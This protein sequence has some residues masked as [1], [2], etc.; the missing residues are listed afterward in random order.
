MDG[1]QYNLFRFATAVLIIIGVQASGQVAVPSS[2]AKTS[3]FVRVKLAKLSF[4]L[5]IEGSGVSIKGA[6][7][8]AIEQASIPQAKKIRVDF[9]KIGGRPLWI[10]T[11]G[12]KI[13]RLNNLFLEI[14][15]E[16]TKVR[17]SGFEVPAPALLSVKGQNNS[18]DVVSAIKFDEYLEG[19]M[20]GEMPAGWP[21]EALKAQAVAARSYTL[22]QMHA[23]QREIYQLEGSILDQAF[24]ISTTD[25]Q[26]EKIRRAIAATENMV[27]FKGNEIL[28]A[29]YHS[30]CG[31][32]TE[33]PEHIWGEGDRKKFAQ[34][35]KDPN[36][37]FNPNS[38]WNLEVTFEE[39]KAFSDFK[40]LKNIKD[41]KVVSRTPS[42][43]ADLIA[44]NDGDNEVVVT[45]ND[46]RKILGYGKLKSTLFSMVKKEKSLVFI[47]RGFGHGSGLCQF[48]AK[49][50]AE[51]G[52]SVRE[53][54]KH[55]YP[56]ARLS[57]FDV[58]NR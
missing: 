46:L 21:M 11:Q 43:R 20:S 52:A 4:P 51:Q 15:S 10:V 25:T 2:G 27:L 47:G 37:A 30:D 56:T 44:F 23:R 50:L 28:K 14:R 33:D 9:K 40:A 18:V 5:Y 57:R 26:R 8:P 35:V 49:Y 32:Q 31:G 16:S 34:G 45:G 19:V 12:D 38:K 7:R 3:E 48:G 1:G 54:L 41:V 29:Y 17:I 22:S 6:S 24:S 55:Y 13:S 42:Q 53:I 39:L 58:A 36:C